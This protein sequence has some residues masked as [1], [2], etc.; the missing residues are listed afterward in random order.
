MIVILPVVVVPVHRF[1][2]RS[3]FVLSIQSTFDSA[4]F[5]FKSKFYGEGKGDKRS[6]WL[7][8]VCILET[9]AAYEFYCSILINDFTFD[10]NFEWT[11]RNFEAPWAQ[12]LIHFL[13]WLS[14]SLTLSLFPK[15]IISM[16]C[17]ENLKFCSSCYMNII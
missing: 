9:A 11:N 3:Y 5:D 4:V 14:L 7:C 6:I 15:K 1:Y 10:R 17:K 13:R 8:K 2:L 12:P 16:F